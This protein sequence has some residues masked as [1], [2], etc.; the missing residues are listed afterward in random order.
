[1]ANPELRGRFMRCFMYLRKEPM[2]NHYAH[3]L[4]LV[5]NL[6]LH[7][8][9]V[10]DCFMQDPAPAVPQHSSNFVAALAQR[11]RPW[12]SGLRPLNIQQPE[13]PSF[14]VAG[15]VISWQ[16]WN[17]RISFN[18]REG[19]VLHHVGCAPAARAHAGECRLVS[20][21]TDSAG[22]GNKGICKVACGVLGNKGS[23][24]HFCKNLMQV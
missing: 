19:L 14:E 17:M 21:A 11:E 10:L 8:R 7:S 18:Y 12:R 22:L 23:I 13:G 3:P 9:R 1:M 16:K 20:T 6:E 15:N 24:P 5:I 4:D 2:E